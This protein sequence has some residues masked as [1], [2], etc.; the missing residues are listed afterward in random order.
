MHLHYTKGPPA[1]KDGAPANGN[2]GQQNQ[3]QNGADG[4]YS[5]GA[6][7]G[8]QRRLPDGLSNSARR[9]FQC[10]NTTPQS[11]EGLHMQDLASRLNIEMAEVGKAG[12]ELLNQGLIYT[13]VD[14]Q[15][16]AILDE[17]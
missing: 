2:Y 6:A 16:W 10:I 11:N 1:A 12:D 7:A 17:F 3:G 8:G 14:D 9:I 15:T 4:S 5:N 13:T